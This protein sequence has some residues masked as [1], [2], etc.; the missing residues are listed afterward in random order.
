MAHTRTLRPSTKSRRGRATLKYEQS[1][2]STE[3]EPC[4]LA[5]SICSSTRPD[6][7]AAT[8]RDLGMM[9]LMVR[10]RNDGDRVIRRDNRFD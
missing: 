9:G 4:D 5:D 1:R 6:S 2:A 3:H 8:D 7:V 10:E